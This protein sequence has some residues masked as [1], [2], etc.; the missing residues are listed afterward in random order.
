MFSKTDGKGNEL[1]ASTKNLAGF[2]L[3]WASSRF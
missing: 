2:L 3:M 1:I